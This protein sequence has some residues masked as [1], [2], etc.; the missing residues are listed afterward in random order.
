MKNQGNEELLKAVTPYIESIE[1]GVIADTLRYGEG[2]VAMTAEGLQSLYESKV[3]ALYDTLSLKSSYIASLYDTLRV[4]PDTNYHSSSSIYI[5]PECH[6]YKVFSWDM[7]RFDTDAE[8]NLAVLKKEYMS[9]KR[10]DD[11]YCQSENE[12]I[13]RSRYNDAVYS[14]FSVCEDYCVLK[15]QLKAFNLKNADGSFAIPRNQKIDIQISNLSL[16]A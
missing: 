7:C 15:A 10:S 4:K 11:S 2:K 3:N 9:V 1:K 12:R 8:T 14:Y 16:L 13:E 5:Y 6:Q